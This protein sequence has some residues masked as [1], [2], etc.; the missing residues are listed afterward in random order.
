MK[1]KQKHHFTGKKWIAALVVVVLILQHLLLYCSS[2][3]NIHNPEL[4]KFVLFLAVI[5]FALY[6]LPKTTFTGD[7]RHPVNFSGNY[8]TKT[9]KFLASLVVVIAAYFVWHAFIFSCY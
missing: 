1:K 9:F 5:I 3:I 2:I 4:W 7:R 6:A 8:K